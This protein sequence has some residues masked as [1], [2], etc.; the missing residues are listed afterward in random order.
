MRYAVARMSLRYLTWAGGKAVD[1]VS[2]SFSPSKNATSAQIRRNGLYCLGLGLL[3]F[4][5]SMG[6]MFTLNAPGLE[7]LVMLPIFLG[8]ALLIVGAY[9]AVLGK[10][11]EPEHPGEASLLRIVFG[12]ATLVVV[13]GALIGFIMLADWIFSG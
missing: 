2:E 10:T 7:K 1:V 13:F 9:R 4:A 12:V 5:A 8:Y 6:V 11:P 3:C